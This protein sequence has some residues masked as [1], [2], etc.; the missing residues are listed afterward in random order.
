[1]RNFGNEPHNHKHALERLFASVG[2]AMTD[3]LA[4]LKQGLKSLLQDRN[5]LIAAI[6]I[7]SV[8]VVVPFL[9]FSSASSSD[10]AAVQFRPRTIASPQAV[11]LNLSNAASDDQRSQQ[12]LNGSVIHHHYHYHY[13]YTNTSSQPSPSPSPKATQP[14]CESQAY[15]DRPTEQEVAALLGHQ[16]R[17]LPPIDSQSPVLS[18]SNWEGLASEEHAGDDWDAVGTETMNTNHTEALIN[19]ICPE[20]LNHPLKMSAHVFAGM[21]CRPQSQL[22]YRRMLQLHVQ[23]RFRHRKLW[24]PRASRCQM[25]HIAGLHTAS[26]QLATMP[27][28]GLRLL[29]YL[30]G[31]RCYEKSTHEV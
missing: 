7:I 6:F 25:Q 12:K 18:T 27:S 15:G 23:V 3:D 10:K 17:Q 20:S 31:G 11:Q 4:R 26:C 8:S 19:A 14:T 29:Q 22:S 21:Q 1:V 2:F 30:P 24:Y 28:S 5:K 13:H 16:I 9:L